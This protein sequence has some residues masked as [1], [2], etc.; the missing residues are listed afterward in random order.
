[1]SQAGQWLKP[2]EAAPVL[3]TSPGALLK[4]IQRHARKGKNGV[5]SRFEGVRARKRGNRWLVWLD[6]GWLQ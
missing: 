4:Q 3:R 2:S 5:E 6:S 1:M